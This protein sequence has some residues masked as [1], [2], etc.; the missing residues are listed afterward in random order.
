M[1]ALVQKAIVLCGLT[2]AACGADWSVQ[3]GLTSASLRILSG[4]DGVAA[5]VKAADGAGKAVGNRGAGSQYIYFDLL[6]RPP[7]GKVF[8]TVEY[9]DAGFGTLALQYDASTRP[10]A[11]ISARYRTADAAVGA[12]RAGTRT[13]RKAAFELHE[14]TFQGRQNLRADFRI[15]AGGDMLIR[16]VTVSAK[17]PADYD[18][19]RDVA[20]VPPAKGVEITIGG[21]DNFDISQTARWRKRL[22]VWLP[23]LRALGAT[24]H[25]TY[26]T[27]RA[28]QPKPGQWDFSHYD[29]CVEAHEKAGLKWVPFLILSPSY[30]LPKWFYGS[31]EH[32]GY[33]CLEHN[34]ETSI[35]SLWHPATRKHVDAFVKAFA[36]RYGRRGVIE[37]VLLGITGNY[38]EAIYPVSD[39]SAKSWTAKPHGPY[40]SHPG[41]WCGDPYARAAFGKWLIGRYGSLAKINAAW[42]TS[43]KKYADAQ[44]VLQAKA[45]SALAWRDTVDFYRHSMNDWADFWLAA[46]RKH[47]PPGTRIYLCTGGHAPPE[48]GSEFGIQ[49]KIAA[50]YGAG[51]RI[52]NEASDYP[53]NFAITRWVSSACRFYGTFF[54]YEPAGHVDHKGVV[55]RIYNATCSGATQLHF[56]A[57][58]L[59]GTKARTAAWGKYGHLMKPRRPRVDV[60][61]WYPNRTVDFRKADVI[62]LLKKMRG[63]CDYDIVDAQMIR[64]GALKGYRNLVCI[65][66]GPY[67]RHTLYKVDGW[68]ASGG[69]LFVPKGKGLAIHDLL[70]QPPRA[71]Y[72]HEL[73]TVHPI[74]A[75]PDLRS[76]FPA[77]ASALSARGVVVLGVAGAYATVFQDGSA[78]LLNMNDK[79]VKVRFRDRPI[80]L[81]PVSI[82]EVPVELP[83]DPFRPRSRRAGTPGG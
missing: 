13:W 27:W 32:V 25:E 77:L 6:S 81:P 76:Y 35:Q 66:P 54:G 60:A 37:S 9:F 20:M 11:P 47:M 57:G 26:V 44:P 38:G 68:L 58:N 4:G 17:P 22:L 24:S 45:P 69:H 75:T 48:H 34:V 1:N 5:V 70:G 71:D 21:Y 56:Y 53:L 80:D 59:L 42:R 12:L 64:D 67:D 83:A 23:P 10:D 50:K 3:D 82:V 78:A 72:W 39:G 46:T 33:R 8:V 31:E 29:A 18:K 61:V 65:S 43:F 28:C 62:F 2:A 7:G 52:T 41:M 14:P 74:A 16:A 19:L 49:S 55:A 73:K 30:S 51:I 63:V 15:H 40:H 36:Q 79:P